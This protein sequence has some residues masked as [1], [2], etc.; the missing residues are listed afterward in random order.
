LRFVRPFRPSRV[1]TLV[2]AVAAGCCAFFG[3]ESQ[4]QVRAQSRAHGER[5]FIEFR[6][7]PSTYIGHTFIHY[8]R[9][10]P[11]GR[12]VE[13]KRLGLIP[14]DD[15]WKGLVF[16]V[17]G[18]VREYKDDTRLPSLVIYDLPPAFD[19]GRVCAGRG[20][21]AADAGERASLARRIFQLQ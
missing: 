17:R 6:A 12:I 8:G 3:D 19:R 1:A 15:A 9:L 21:G 11:S 4:A 5:H 2:A 14:E 10:D 13:S 20:G 18:T 16:P 7:R